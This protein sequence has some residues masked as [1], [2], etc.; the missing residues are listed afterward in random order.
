MPGPDERKSLL[1]EPGHRGYVAGVLDC[2]GSIW[3]SANRSQKHTQYALRVSVTNT[4][5]ALPEWFA[6]HFGGKTIRCKKNSD[7]WKD[8]YRWQV[9]GLTALPVLRLCLPYLVIKREQALLGIE[10]TSTIIPGQKQLPK[11]F[12][13]MRE[14]L[15]DRMI[16][17]NKRGPA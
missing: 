13:A 11:S 14:Q 1:L 4:R 9:S 8:E 10:F 15:Y 7:K 3:I 2:D 16:A 6:E 12:R 5:P 17:L